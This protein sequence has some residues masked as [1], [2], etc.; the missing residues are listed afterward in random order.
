VVLVV[1]FAHHFRRHSVAYIQRQVYMHPT[2]A[3]PML[4]DGL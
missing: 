2:A 3:D 1:V 4:R